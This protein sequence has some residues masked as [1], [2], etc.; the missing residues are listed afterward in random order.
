LIGQFGQL[1]SQ[2]LLNSQL[3]QQLQSELNYFLIGQFA[4]QLLFEGF[5]AR[6][7]QSKFTVARPTFE[8]LRSLLGVYPI[9]DLSKI[10]SSHGGIG[11][12]YIYT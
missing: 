5:L 8:C 9:C 12:I 11:I 7:L 10:A 6:E 1:A 3:A 2:V 4:R